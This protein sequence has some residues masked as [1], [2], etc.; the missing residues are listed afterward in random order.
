M[1]VSKIALQKVAKL[2]WVFTRT[3]IYLKQLFCIAF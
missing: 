2:L 3:Y 1:D